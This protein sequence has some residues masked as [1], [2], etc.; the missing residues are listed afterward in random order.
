M[1]HNSSHPT[2]PNTLSHHNNTPTQVAPSVEEQNLSYQFDNAMNFQGSNMNNLQN[3]QLFGNDSYVTP[4]KGK[5]WLEPKGYQEMT[6]PKG[7]K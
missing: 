7:K 5:E 4:E 2:H 6:K 1:H 3:N